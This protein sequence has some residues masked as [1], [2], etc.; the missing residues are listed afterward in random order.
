MKS[1][2]LLNAR[3]HSSIVE[4]MSEIKKF[5]TIFHFVLFRSFNAF[6]LYLK[7]VS[8]KKKKHVLIGR[9]IFM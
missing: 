3:E 5:F 7:N 6:V 1:L 8:D 2:T 4:F 9:K